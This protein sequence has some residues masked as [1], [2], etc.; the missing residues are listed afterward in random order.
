MAK[1]KITSVKEGMRDLHIPQDL[2]DHMIAA[3]EYAASNLRMEN[4]GDVES[5]GD[6]ETKEICVTFKGVDA[7]IIITVTPEKF[8]VRDDTRSDVED[9]T[10]WTIS[11]DIKYP[12]TWTVTITMSTYIET[13]RTWITAITES[14]TFALEVK[15]KMDELIDQ[16]TDDL[17]S[18]ECGERGYHFPKA[19]E[20]IISDIEWMANC[21]FIKNGRPDYSAIHSFE[22]KNPN[23]RIEPGETDS[24]GWL[25]GVLVIDEEKAICWG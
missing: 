3:M 15:W 13:A 16:L 12:N 2:Q 18:E 7:N 4:T 10:N 17:F 9:Y 6:S 23:C 14:D 25:T 20:G 11:K 19:Y 22:K 5:T 21:R 24:F 8:S 1:Q